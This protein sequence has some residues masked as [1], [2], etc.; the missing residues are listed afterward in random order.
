MERFRV[1]LG[2]RSYDIVIGNG[3]LGDLRLLIEEAVGERKKV[4]LV[5]NP[6]VFGLYG[7]QVVNTLGMGDGNL[8]LGMVPDGEEY[9][10]MEQAQ[11]LI[12][13]LIDHQFDRY[14]LILALGGGVIGDLAG[15]VAA[16]Y[17][18]GI[19]YIQIP[20]TLL[21]QVDSSV[22]GKTAVNHPQGKNMI[23]AFHQPRLVAIDPLVLKTLEDRDYLSGLAEMV[24]YG[25]IADRH[26]F[27]FLEHNAA[28]INAR[29]YEVLKP[30]ILWACRIKAAIVEQDEREGGLRALLNL[31]HTFGHAIE[32]HF[33][34]GYYRHGEA[35]AIG[36]AMAA[37]LANDLKILDD[38]A[39][40]SI[41]HLLQILHLD[42]PEPYIP[43]DEFVNLMQMDK[44][45]KNGQVRLVLPVAVGRAII[46]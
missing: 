43:S 20:T 42:Y 36:I 35:V 28:A 2:P 1:E 24:K 19:D 29:N 40:T 38:K 14:S 45:V 6:T 32:A 9:K 12:D 8:V 17:Q 22:G 37:R 27:A 25:I 39:L 16:I 26:Y 30:A 4:L 10:T 11:R 15:F 3:V 21:A 31:G 34:F 13:L 23:G 18:R 33:G 46:K 44:K 7:S 41:L 5:T